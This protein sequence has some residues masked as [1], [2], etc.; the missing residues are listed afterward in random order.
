MFSYRACC[1]CERMSQDERPD[2]DEGQDDLYAAFEA[3][4]GQEHGGG[5]ERAHPRRQEGG[6][7]RNRGTQFPYRRAGRCA[8]SARQLARECAW[9]EGP[10]RRTMRWVAP[11]SRR[12]VSGSCAPVERPCCGGYLDIPAEAL[13]PHFQFRRAVRDFHEPVGGPIIEPTTNG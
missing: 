1:G 3:L 12:S 6:P 4:G 13:K 10:A 2:E 9:C 11:D 7:S 5:A 8:A